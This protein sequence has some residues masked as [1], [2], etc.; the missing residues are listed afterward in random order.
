MHESLAAVVQHQQPYML[1][2][3]EVGG[4]CQVQLP[5][6]WWNGRQIQQS[7]NYTRLIN[8]TRIK[9]LSWLLRR[10]IWLMSHNIPVESNALACVSALIW[11]G[12]TGTENSGWTSGIFSTST[13]ARVHSVLLMASF[14]RSILLRTNQLVISFSL[15][16]YDKKAVSTKELRTPPSGLR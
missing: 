14:S 9:H 16:W 3:E 5:W 1:K 7:W 10:N 8:L 11:L 13:F 12:T 15:V 4:E 2:E 6:G